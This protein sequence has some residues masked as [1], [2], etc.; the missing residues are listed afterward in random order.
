M[1]EF[2]TRK[3]KG[4]AYSEAFTNAV[5]R[6]KEK[7]VSGGASV[8]MKTISFKDSSLK[9]FLKADKEKTGQWDL[10]MKEEFQF[11]SVEADVFKFDFQSIDKK[12]FTH[13]AL[14]FMDV[15][16]EM[17]ASRTDDGWRLPDAEDIQRLTVNIAHA[18]EAADP[19]VPGFTFVVFCSGTQ[20]GM[21]SQGFQKAAQAVPAMVSEPHRGVAYTWYTVRSVV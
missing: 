21:V 17:V 8:E 16:Y 4:T 14:A 18:A 5:K 1:H 13:M 10:S 2:K 11:C 12:V 3:P 7:I 9:E 6:M 15:P 19:P 20:I